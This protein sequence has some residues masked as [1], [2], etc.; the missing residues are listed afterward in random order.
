MHVVW[1]S[2]QEQERPSSEAQT[3]FTPRVA[4]PRTLVS[5]WPESPVGQSRHK[6][7]SIDSTSDGRHSKLTGMGEVLWPFL[8]KFSPVRNNKRSQQEGILTMCRLGCG[9]MGGPRSSRCLRAQVES[10][11]ILSSS[12]VGAASQRSRARL[13]I[14]GGREGGR[15]FLG[16]VF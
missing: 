8:E 3:L 16:S 6:G 10:V 15:R 2:S 7:V 14:L 13:R 1:K 4:S 5:H 9:L 12:F 11:F